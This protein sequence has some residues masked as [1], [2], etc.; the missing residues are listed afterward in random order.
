MKE[1]V[2]LNIFLVKLLQLS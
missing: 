1:G 2:E